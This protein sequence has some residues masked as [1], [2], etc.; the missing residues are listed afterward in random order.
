VFERAGY[1]AARAL[2]EAV[3]LAM[4]KFSL[5]PVSERKAAVAP[6]EDPKAD[7][8]KQR[9]AEATARG[10]D[11]AKAQPASL[12]NLGTDSD[13]QGMQHIDPK[14]LSHDDFM[15]LPESTLKRLRGDLI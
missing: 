10:I 14:A 13:K 5:V 12:Q 6:K 11:T 7:A 3:E 15:K 8:G 2:Q 1:S 4:L 9:L